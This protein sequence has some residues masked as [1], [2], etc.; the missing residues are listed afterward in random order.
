MWLG[1]SHGS[2]SCSCG[3]SA[4]ARLRSSSEVNRQLAAA[5]KDASD[6]AAAEAG[7]VLHFLSVLAEIPC[8][9]CLM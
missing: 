1:W 5:A 9:C 7:C 6:L 4:T 2:A 8:D 3:D